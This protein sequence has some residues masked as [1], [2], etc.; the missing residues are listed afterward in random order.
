MR[1]NL[2]RFKLRWRDRLDG[3]GSDA[4]GGLERKYAQ[5]YWTELFECF[6]V[7]ASRMDLFEQD[8]RRAST[9]KAGYIDLF[10]PGVVI[11]EAKKPGVDLQVAVDQ[12]RD[13]LLGGT[14]TPS[15]QPVT[16]SPATSSASVWCG[17]ARQSSAST[18]SSRSRRSPST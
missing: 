2:D 16:F 3:W 17:S 1:Q 6:G 9:G 11:G 10:W 13:Y 5:S 4:E 7:T 18:L 12:A 15:E 14:I 8:A